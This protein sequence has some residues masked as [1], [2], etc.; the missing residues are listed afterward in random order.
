MFKEKEELKNEIDKDPLRKLKFKIELKKKTLEMVKK[1]QAEGSLKML[2]EDVDK[3]IYRLEKVIF[4]LEN[5]LNAGDFAKELEEIKAK[6][7]EGDIKAL[8]EE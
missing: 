7:R 8:M 2:Q 1:G 5:R 6:K 3:W 4:E